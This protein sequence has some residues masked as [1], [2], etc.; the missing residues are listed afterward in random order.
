LPRRNDTNY[1]L[2]AYYDMRYMQYFTRY[3]FVQGLSKY[4]EDDTA[5]EREEMHKVMEKD[6]HRQIRKIE[7]KRAEGDDDTKPLRVI[8]RSV[9]A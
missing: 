4:N 2:D 3:R 1:Q 9:Q 7:V 8:S 5:F 6:Y